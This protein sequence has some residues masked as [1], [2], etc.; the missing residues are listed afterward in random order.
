MKKVFDVFIFIVFLVLLVC[1]G[2]F[3]Y[4]KFFGPEITTV[5]Y[6]N[7]GEIETTEGKKNFAEVNYYENKDGTGIELF[8]IK[9]NYHVNYESKASYASGLQIIGE[10]ALVWD[11]DI[12]NLS[13]VYGK[14]YITENIYYYKMDEIAYI[15]SDPIKEDDFY[16]INLNDETYMLTFGRNRLYDKELFVSGYATSTIWE[17]AD[18]M[19]KAVKS[20]KIGSFD[21]VFELQDLFNISK[22]DK[23]KNEYVE[24]SDVD[25]ILTYLYIKVNHYTTGAKT[26]NDSIFNCIEGN[27]SFSVEGFTTSSE[28][29]ADKSYI[30]LTEQDFVFK[31]DEENYCHTATLNKNCYEYLQSK[32]KEYGKLNI[33]VVIDKDYLNEIG[34]LFNTLESTYLSELGIE[35]YTVIENGIT[36]EVQL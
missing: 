27:A 19:Y 35:S 2:L 9:F 13:T 21:N 25:S 12:A 22:L 29:F 16:T 26:V 15:N 23:E 34:V 7:F 33:E 20:A 10:P 5:G 1:D 8:E 31:Y 28:Y 3:I 24:F 36:S 14:A 6:V 18:Y 4:Y 17:Y 11:Y 32:K 30:K